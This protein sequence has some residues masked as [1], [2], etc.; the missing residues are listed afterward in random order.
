MEDIE[1]KVCQGDEKKKKKSGKG[2][3]VCVP[4]ELLG[5]MEFIVKLYVVYMGPC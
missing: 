1:R 5:H 4:W 3:T 2:A